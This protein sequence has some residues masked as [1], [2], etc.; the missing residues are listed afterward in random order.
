M[1]S[2]PTTRARPKTIEVHLCRN[3]EML[4][5]AKRLRYEVYCEELGRRSPYADHDKKVITDHLDATGHV[6]VA[7]EAGET[8]GT[9]R[10]NLSVDTLSWAR[11]RNCTG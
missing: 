9:L 11:W 7:I 5:R 6:F 4:E 3:K 2:T 8:I 1:G 10:G